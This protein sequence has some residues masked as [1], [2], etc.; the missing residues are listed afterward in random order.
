MLI[1]SRF[2]FA[3]FITPFAAT[4]VPRTEYYYRFFLSAILIKGRAI[5]EAVSRR[6]PT[7]AVRVRSQVRSYGIC[8]GQSDAGVGFLRV[9][10]FPLLFLIPLTAPHSSSIIRSWYSGPNSG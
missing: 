4:A 1:F 9:L 5:D 3:V 8:G 7:S 2:T 10:R 6:V